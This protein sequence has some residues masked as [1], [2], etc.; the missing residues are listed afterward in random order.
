MS[1]GTGA[2]ESTRRIIAF[3]AAIREMD[4]DEA[5]TMYLQC[6]RLEGQ[7]LETKR[8]REAVFWGALAAI[9]EER[10]AEKAA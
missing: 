6:K 3:A 9:L 10:Y 2:L 7:Y 1:N 8:K 4:Q 5:Y